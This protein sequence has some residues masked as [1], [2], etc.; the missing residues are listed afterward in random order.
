MIAD[1]FKQSKPIVFLFLGILLS[2]LYYTYFI[3]NKDLT[4][5]LQQ[6][7]L[8]I[9]NHFILVVTF[10]LFELSIKHYEIQKGHSLA[11]LFFVL[12]VGLIIPDITS[13]HELLSFLI[14]SL[15]TIRIFAS[16]EA[17]EKNLYI[18][19]AVLLIAIASLFYKPA[20][21]YLI[22][23][24]AAILLFSRSNWRYFVIPVFS[25]STLIIFVEFYFL[26]RYDTVA[27]LDFFIPKIEYSLEVYRLRL[28]PT[29]IT[30]WIVSCLVCIYQIYSVKRIRSL[31]HKKMAT[32]FL[33]F[34]LLS[35]LSIGFKSS[36]LS[37]LWLMS[38]WPLCIYLGDFISRIKKRMWLYVWFLGFILTGTFLY[39]FRL[40]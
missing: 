28:N 39:V 1:F 25:I 38:I 36:T 7:G 40:V 16:I 4:L 19:E 31:Y 32:F 23:V 34:L 33:I 13:Y 29:L 21:L 12:F 6:T 10:I 9:L 8:I 14:L 24:L 27:R 5:S 2:L 15:G 3:V 17:E 30:F 37:G 11:S 35:V 22:L 26:L 18:Y 20:I